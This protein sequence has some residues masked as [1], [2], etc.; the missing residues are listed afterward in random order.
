MAP[1]L[2]TKLINEGKPIIKYGDGRSKRDYTFVNDIVQGVIAASET[3]Y[4][5]EI[6]NL[7]NSQTVELNKFISIIEKLIGKKAKII[8]KDMPKEDVP[9]TYADISKAKKLLKY[10]PKTNIQQGM[11]KFIEWYKSNI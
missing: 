10:N 2:F 3:N 1:Y 6:F 7:G 4:S 11:K 8:Q 5:F 9:I